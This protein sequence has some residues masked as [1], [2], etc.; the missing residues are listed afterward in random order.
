MIILYPFLPNSCERETTQMPFGLRYHFVE[1]GIPVEGGCSMNPIGSDRKNII[2]II[3]YNYGL[4]QRN[5]KIY[6]SFTYP[7][8]QCA[9]TAIIVL[10]LIEYCSEKAE[11]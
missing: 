7:Q 9:P 6:H 1:S 3:N 2:S 11:L 5:S 10:F 4:I 8:I